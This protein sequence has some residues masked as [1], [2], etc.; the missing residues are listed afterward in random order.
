MNFSRDFKCEITDRVAGEGMH[1]ALGFCQLGDLTNKVGGCGEI[2][3]FA[4]SACEPEAVF[5]RSDRETRHC[6]A[7]VG[8]GVQRWVVLSPLY[9][10][11]SA[12]TH[13]EPRSLKSREFLL[14]SV[15][16]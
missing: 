2:A 8:N 6:E 13:I 12:V 10:Q 5:E 14:I 7:Q 9:L 1:S 11:T 3:G 16:I 15:V 4:D